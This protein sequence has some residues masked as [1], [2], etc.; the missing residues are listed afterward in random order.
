MLRRVVVS[1]SLL[2]SVMAGG[3][4]PLPMKLRI[5]AL[6]VIVLILFAATAAA[7]VVVPGPPSS[8]T[9]DLWIGGSLF[10]CGVIGIIVI[11]TNRRA[12][13]R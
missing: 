9:R 10:L 6:L 1:G 5:R 2:A 12:R 7:D 8:G 3:A 13:E 4:V 11:R